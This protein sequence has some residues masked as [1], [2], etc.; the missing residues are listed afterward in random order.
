MA[1]QLGT[2]PSGREEAEALW[3]RALALSLEPNDVSMLDIMLI[4]LKPLLRFLPHFSATSN[5]ERESF[6]NCMA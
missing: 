1:L 6:I 3:R 2:E 5:Q 4:Q